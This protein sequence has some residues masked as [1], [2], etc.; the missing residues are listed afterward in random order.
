MDG[1]KMTILTYLAV[2]ACLFA[3]VIGGLSLLTE[4]GYGFD[5]RNRRGRRVAKDGRRSGRRH[6]DGLVRAK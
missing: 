6:R 5:L 4:S 1:Q 3:L 2:F